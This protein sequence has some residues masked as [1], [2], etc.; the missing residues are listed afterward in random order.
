MFDVFG[1]V[2][3]NMFRCVRCVWKCGWKYVFAKHISK[4][5]SK[6]IDTSYHSN[7]TSIHPPSTLLLDLQCSRRHHRRRPMRED[8]PHSSI[9][10]V[11]L[12]GRRT[13]SRSQSAARKYDCSRPAIAP[14]IKAMSMSVPLNAY[15]CG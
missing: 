9:I 11:P 15:L 7:M 10:P 12:S 4:H 8:L 5:I 13:S 6:H 14:R 2:F 3:G 1:N